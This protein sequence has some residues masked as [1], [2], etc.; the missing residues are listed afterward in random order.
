MEAVEAFGEQLGSWGEYVSPGDR[1]VFASC[2]LLGRD[3]SSFAPYRPA[4]GKAWAER[5]G[6]AAGATPGERY[7]SLLS[8]C[9]GLRER[10]D[11]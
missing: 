10:W 3:A 11:R 7:G 8:L 5:V 6:E 2:L 4:L 9:D 1:T